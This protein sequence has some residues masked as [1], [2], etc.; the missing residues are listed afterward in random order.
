MDSEFEKRVAKEM[1]CS[2]QFVNNIHL[3]SSCQYHWV[4]D[5]EKRLPKY[6]PGRRDYLPMPYCSRQTCTPQPLAVSR[7]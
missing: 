3:K 7:E 4:T 1:A 6:P 2:Q 5:N